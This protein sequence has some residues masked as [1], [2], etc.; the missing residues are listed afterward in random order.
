M[1]TRTVV[2]SG[3]SGLIGSALVPALKQAGHRVLCLVRHEARNQTEIRW[4]P[5]ARLFDARLVSSVDVLVNLAGE[6]V[7]KRWTASRRRR[8][9][10]SRVDGTD[11]L[12]SAIGQSRRRPVSL[13]NA[14]A[15]GIYGD[16]GSEVLDENHPPGRGFLAE[17]CR[18]WEHAANA[19]TKHGARVVTMRTGVVLSARGGALPKMLLPFRLGIGGKIGDGR[20]WISWIGIDDMIRAIMWLIEHEDISGPVNMSSPNPVTNADFTRT[21]GETIHRPT[22]M[23]V[24]GIALQLALV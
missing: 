10:S 14:S 15:V 11:L 2:V 5:A 8:I 13:I 3:S 6:S 17:I 22:F 16:R 19:A 21:L 20:Q 9:R 23:R 1:P 12:V 24:P 4:N 18:Q 7:A